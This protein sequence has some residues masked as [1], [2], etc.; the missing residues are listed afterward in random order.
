M[1]HA[2]CE[3][4][5]KAH[6]LEMCHKDVSNDPGIRPGTSAW[7]PLCNLTPLTGNGC[8]IKFLLSRSRMYPVHFQP[9]ITSAPVNVLKRSLWT[10][11]RPRLALVANGQPLALGL[12]GSEVK[13]RSNRVMFPWISSRKA[14]CTRCR[15]WL[16]LA[17]RTE[18]YV[19]CALICTRGTREGLHLED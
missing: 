3:Q 10:P 17:E 5:P 6:T 2:F 8:V 15:R 4:N 11:L 12:P 18:G 19:C 7:R 14:F 1:S 13:R 9:W 16:H